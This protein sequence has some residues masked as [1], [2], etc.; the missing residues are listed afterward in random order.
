MSQTVHDPTFALTVN[1]HNTDKHHSSNVSC[2]AGAEIA[3]AYID[4]LPVRMWACFWGSY[5]LMCQCQGC[6]RWWPEERRDETLDNSS[7]L[8]L[9]GAVNWTSTRLLTTSWDFQWKLLVKSLCFK[10]KK[11]EKKKT[12]VTAHTHTHTDQPTLAHKN[13]A[14]VEDVTSN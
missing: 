9:D 5:G 12:K 1:Q 11:E 2:H 3:M 13:Q 14:G 6:L 8:E 10:N 4:S 7:C